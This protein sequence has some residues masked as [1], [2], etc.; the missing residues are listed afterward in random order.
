M[1]HW[2]VIPTILVTAAVA[3]MIGLGIWQIQRMGEKEAVLARYAAAQDKPA[4]TYPAVPVESEL[5]LFRRS[6]LNC[7]KVAGWQSVSGKRADG[8]AGIAHLAECQTGGGE[9]PGALVA[10]GWTN[11]P[12]NPDWKGGAV[13]GV[14]APDN[15]RL[16]KLVVTDDV[17]G[18]QKLAPPS[19]DSIPNNHLIYAIQWFFFAFAAAVIF[20]LAVRKKM[21]TK[22]PQQS[23]S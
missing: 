12:E 16:I 22:E 18:L 5:P 11:K 1:K 3:T 17:P 9:G 23:L 13:Q 21:Q 4:V 20:L 7:V 8:E 6:A 19:T 10:V 14:I 2:P 15:N